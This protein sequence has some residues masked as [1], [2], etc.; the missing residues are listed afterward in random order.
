M[1]VFGPFSYLL[2]ELGFDRGGRQGWENRLSNWKW[3]VRVVWN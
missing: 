2:R 1:E 3:W